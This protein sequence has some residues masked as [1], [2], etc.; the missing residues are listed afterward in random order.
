MGHFSVTLNLSNNEF[1]EADILVYIKSDSPISPFL[2]VIFPKSFVQFWAPCLKTGVDRIPE[3]NGA[4][5][6][7]SV[8]IEFDKQESNVC[9]AEKEYLKSRRVDY[10]DD[11]RNQGEWAG[12]YEM[13]LSCAL[14]SLEYCFDCSYKVQSYPR[15][16]KDSY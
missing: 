14:W 9:R 2:S 13:H 8:P 10:I 7:C 5:C 12:T 3:L 15:V 4:E 6:I 16:F 11:L 1:K